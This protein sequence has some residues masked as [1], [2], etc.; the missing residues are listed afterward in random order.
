[1]R[2]R[3]AQ[4]RC[5]EICPSSKLRLRR[6]VPPICPPPPGRAIIDGFFSL[7]TFFGLHHVRNRLVIGNWK[8]NGGLAANEAL[9]ALLIERVSQKSGRVCGVCAPFPYLSQLQVK[10]ATSSIRWGSQDVSRYESGAFT[11]E[12]SAGMVAEFGC[13]FALV[14]HSERRALFAETDAIVAEKF[15]RVKKAGLAPI[16]CVGE[17]LAEREAGATNIVV[18]RQLTAVVAAHGVAALQGAVVAYEPVWAIGTGK[19]ASPQEAEAVHAFLR[20]E[21]AKL[22]GA[23]AAQ[24][25]ILYGGSVKKA[26]AAELFAMPNIDG[27]LIGGASLVAEDFLGIWAAL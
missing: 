20:G 15:G 24:L 12:V 26:N 19:T 13:N 22:D 10:L 16:L 7:R 11:G 27:G 3:C 14:G 2:L 5:R 9:L 18:A 8:L 21:V 6:R 25:P 17:T 1:M 4:S 23:V